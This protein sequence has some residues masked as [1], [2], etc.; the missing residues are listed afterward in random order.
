MTLG[1][2]A[3]VAWGMA[4]GAVPLFIFF[5]AYHRIRRE[6]RVTRPYIKGLP[7]GFVFGVLT[8][9]L[10]LGGASGESGLAFVAFSPFVVAGFLVSGFFVATFY[11][12]RGR[13]LFPKE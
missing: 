11:G 1:I 9:L 10:L 6:P 4:A 2:L 5:E 8:A 13:P 3:V 12:W 7:A